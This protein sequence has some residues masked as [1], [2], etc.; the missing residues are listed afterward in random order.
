MKINGET[1]RKLR[2]EKGY[3]QEEMAD[4]I[5][6]GMRNYQRMETGQVSVGIW[7]F[8]YFCET[9]GVPEQEFWSLY[10]DSKDYD[11]YRKYRDLHKMVRKKDYD[12]V[13]KILPEFEK[14]SL[15]KQK[16][17]KQFIA[18][19][20][21]SIDK[22]SVDE[23]KMQT[24][25]ETLRI[26]MKNYDENELH[27]YNLNYNEIIIIDMMTNILFEKGETKRAISI[28][29]TIINRRNE[30]KTSEEDRAILFPFLAF[31][32]SNF[33]GKTEKYKEARK[34]CNESIEICRDYNQLSYV[35]LLLYNLACCD[36]KLGEEEQVYKTNLIR[37]YHCAYA[38]GQNGIAK[39]IKDDAKESFG[40]VI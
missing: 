36:Y 10:L 38:Q 37:S 9:L 32:L 39:I 13:R 2:I 24:L 11:D 22:E 34:V 20:K 12:A 8:L 6:V 3:T 31:T 21:I 5:N 23:Q 27:K 14:G 15:A 40:I 16:Y 33:L 17:V 25:D 4:K 35:P 1:I 19:V 29:Q 18:F 7:D 26:S 28:I 30:S